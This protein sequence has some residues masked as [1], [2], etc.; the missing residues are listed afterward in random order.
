MPLTKPGTNAVTTRLNTAL[1]VLAF[2]SAASGCAWLPTGSKPVA[3]A[4]SPQRSTS[5]AVQPAYRVTHAGPDALYQ[6]GRQH[7]LAGRQE[8]AV[9]QFRAALAR[10]PRHVDAMSS[11]AVALYGLGRQAEALD[12][13]RQAVEIAPDAAH[14]RNNYGYALHKAGR[15][16]RARAELNAALRLQ[17]G[18]AS[19]R[20]NLAMLDAPDASPGA[21]HAAGV[22]D[23]P[24]G[25]PAAAAR[26]RPSVGASGAAAASAVQ[27][28]ADD[29]GLRPAVVAA[30]VGG[31]ALVALAPNVYE[32]RDAQA[33]PDRLFAA[34]FEP[35]ATVRPAPSGG[36]VG[37]GA[38]RTALPPL[39][40]KPGQ[41]ATPPAASA[42]AGGWPAAAGEAG[43]RVAVTAELRRPAAAAAAAKAPAPASAEAETSTQAAD[44]GRDAASRQAPALQARQPVA[45]G[46]TPAA[47]MEPVAT[48]TD[49]AAAF[50]VLGLD[51][52][53]P[54]TIRKASMRAG[55]GTALRVLGLEASPAAATGSPV[56]A[57]PRAME[58]RP[59][60]SLV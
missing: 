58:P 26:S 31:S 15:T 3:G 28:L 24:V 55:E 30:A 57:K 46:L 13:L 53:P 5:S 50:R 11:L 4:S 19:A 54:M 43:V 47:R 32:L 38:K 44:A 60:A 29:G 6:L 9:E 7:L 17:P 20:L 35:N 48:R 21:A 16:E 14:L 36:P 40:A 27:A 56:K 33:A 12:L 52:N 59:P 37:H 39:V 25:Q 23:G 10:Q 45:A 49:Q 51:A 1:C 22:P 2:T 8:A 42:R 18:H 41:P 34:G